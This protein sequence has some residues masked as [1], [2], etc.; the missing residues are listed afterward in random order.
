MATNALEEAVRKSVK[1]DSTSRLKQ[2]MKIGA[3]IFSEED[4]DAFSRGQLI[5]Y[6]VELR[7]AAGKTESVKAV[8]E[9]F[10]PSKAKV[11]SEVPKGAVGG[12]SVPAGDPMA[13]MMAFMQS[14]KDDRRIEEEEKTKREQEKENL[15]M[16]REQE[17]EKLRMQVELEKDKLKI[18][19]EEKRMQIEEER[20]KRQLKLEEEKIK[21]EIERQNEMRD[22]RE[23]LQAEREEDRERETLRNNE[24][25]KRYTKKDEDSE[26]RDIRLAKMA[27]T[28]K[29]LLYSLPYDVV[30]ILMWFRRVEELFEL[31]QVD[32][33]IKTQLVYSFMN[34]KARRIFANLAVSEKDT[35][36]HLKISL[37]REFRL[38]PR[39]CR[40]GYCE[41]KK[42]RTESNVQFVSRLR[43]LL[44]CYLESRQVTDSFEDLVELLLT[45][46]FTDSLS[47]NQR[48][49][50]A[51]KQ[52]EA[53]NKVHTITV[54]I[55]G[56]EAERMQLSNASNN[57]GNVQYKKNNMY[58]LRGDRWEPHNVTQGKQAEEQKTTSYGDKSRV[59]SGP[60]TGN[61][62]QRGE[63][64][65][66]SKGMEIN[67]NKRY[68]VNLVEV[69][70]SDEDQQLQEEDEQRVVEENVSEVNKITVSEEEC[71]EINRL[72]LEK[73]NSGLALVGNK[74]VDKAFIIKVN[75]Q[76]CRCIVDS[77]CEISM[78][79]PSMIV[80]KEDAEEDEKAFIWV[81]GAFGSP[82][83]AQ[84]KNV[85]VSLRKEEEEGLKRNAIQITCAI[86]EHL[87]SEYALITKADYEMMLQQ[88]RLDIPQICLISGTS[89]LVEEKNKDNVGDLLETRLLN[90]ID[91]QS[92][93][94][95]DKMMEREL[96]IDF[97][98]ESNEDF[99]KMQEEDETLK[100]CWEDAKKK[101]EVDSK[102][103]IKTENGLLYRKTIKAGIEIDQLVLPKCKR[104]VVMHT[105][106]HSQWALHLGIDKTID[107]LQM[108]FFGQGLEVRWRSMLRLVICARKRQ[109]C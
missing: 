36:E 68:K 74:L 107:R 55:D 40:A 93:E 20:Y 19:A 95:G 101:D 72:M 75:D 97:E 83:R 57:R 2:E 53:R 37:V 1:K 104:K 59:K 61:S 31:N 91:I 66:G 45:D 42:T 12:V 90:K 27:K 109:G 60:G 3:S 17:K 50:L 89:L 16:Q 65:Q 98:M 54:W 32:E 80:E 78:F 51:D 30:G 64:S 22:E 76:E 102:Y 94:K 105:A 85:Q 26:K 56:Y 38:S 39:M 46:R 96:E 10:D 9:N 69:E 79:R 35:Y 14:M 52:G 23:R 62:W 24:M 13:M 44:K 87:N 8:V 4:I 58:T 11:F 71:L 29:T 63:A 77:G 73:G 15:K 70:S 99:R 18:Q 41:A 84:I 25:D 82:V 49:F 92:V 6:I 103:W 100:R 48:Y 81:Q 21:V 33:D 67:R 108:Y 43:T 34:D 47:D 7:K 88:D 5:E 86:S 28:F 106:H